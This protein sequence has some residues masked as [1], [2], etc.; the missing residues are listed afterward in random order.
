MRV[1]GAGSLLAFDNMQ[2][3]PIKGTTDW[4]RYDVVLDV[5]PEAKAL[6]FGLLLAGN[7]QIWFDDLRLEVVDRSVA[8]TMPAAPSR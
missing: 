4:K 7:G 2:N 1:D 8:V 5:P 6:A 3:R